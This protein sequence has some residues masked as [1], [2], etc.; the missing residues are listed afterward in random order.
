[1]LTS[2]HLS[3]ISYNSEDFLKRV[4]NEKLH[5]HQIS[6]WCYIKHQKEEEENKDHIHLFFIPDTRLDTVNLDEDFVEPVQGEELPLKC[7]LW[8]KVSSDFD[9]F[10]YNVH[11][12]V[13]LKLKYAE[14]KKIHYKKEDFVYSDKDIFERFWFQAYH[15]YDFWKSTKYR[16]F[17]D[18]GMS[19]KDIVKSGY[20]D[21]KEMVNFHYFAKMCDDIL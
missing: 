9:W 17:I 4:L 18:S 12:P 10:L 7:M 19:C 16:K 20:V 8:F 15:E 6:F 14:D 3:N 2:V 11:D 1:M 21:L 5:K 13:Y